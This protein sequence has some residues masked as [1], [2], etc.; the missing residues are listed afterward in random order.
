[1]HLHIIKNEIMILVINYLY[2]H[3]SKQ[4]E[5]IFKTSHIWLCGLE[6]P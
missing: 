3:H 1:M 6:A 2:L 5:K 4:L